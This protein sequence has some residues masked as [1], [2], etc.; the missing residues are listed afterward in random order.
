[1][2]DP[3]KCMKMKTP[4]WSQ[5]IILKKPELKSYLAFIDFFVFAEGT[6]LPALLARMLASVIS[7]SFFI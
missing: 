2:S 5:G 3:E 4:A 7:L 1:M 6:V